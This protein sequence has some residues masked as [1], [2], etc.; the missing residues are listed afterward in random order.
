MNKT[1]VLGNGINQSFER[2][3]WQNLMAEISGDKHFSSDLPM[4]LQVV[5]ATDNKV[6]DAMKRICN[7]MRG[8]VSNN[9]HREL[10]RELLC[11][12]FNDI[13][14][15]NYS[16]ELEI[17]STDKTSI[18]DYG[19]DK[20]R[21]TTQTGKR[22]E[23]KYLIHTFNRVAINNTESRIWHIHGE[24]RN[25]SGM[26]IGHYYYGNLL[27]KIKNYVDSLDNRYLK[28]ERD[29]IESTVKS[30]IDSF[31]L[32]DVFIL[33]FGFDV[34][35]MDLWWLLE[36][37]KREKAHHGKIYFFCPE[38]EAD[39]GDKIK[40]LEKSGVEICGRDI[41]VCYKDYLGFYKAALSQMYCM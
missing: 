13:I 16:Y 20:M 23:T 39:K 9:E 29:G 18:S 41:K 35:E 2:V 37:K 7:S 22:V 1:L 40:L 5:L 6:D 14:T 32:D 27:T 30:W 4:P 24:A 8:T 36:R 17:A 26:V 31:I 12:G 33:G 38:W 19:L 15:T 25:P 21:E 28:N 10:L 34:S 11:Y 3:S